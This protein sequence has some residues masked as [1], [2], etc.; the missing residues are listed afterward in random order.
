MYGEL[1]VSVVV[2]SE[3][4]QPRGEED[5]VLKMPAGFALIL[6]DLLLAT[7]RDLVVQKVAGSDERAQ[8]ALGILFAEPH[9]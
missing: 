1:T 3:Y 7:T 6:A 9:R 5:I 2:P 4:V 8:K